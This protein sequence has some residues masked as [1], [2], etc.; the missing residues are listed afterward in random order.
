MFPLVF[1]PFPM[2]FSRPHGSTVVKQPMRWSLG[3]GI[4]QRGNGTVR[5]LHLL[6]TPRLVLHVLATSQGGGKASL[7]RL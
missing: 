1:R 2:G 3:D 6:Q 7:Q 5:V 4:L